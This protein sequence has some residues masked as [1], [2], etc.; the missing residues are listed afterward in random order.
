MA[1]RHLPGV[2]EQNVGIFSLP[3]FAADS[4][5]SCFSR[6]SLRRFFLHVRDLSVSFSVVYSYEPS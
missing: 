3:G 6:G 2:A 1:G 5:Q 4:G